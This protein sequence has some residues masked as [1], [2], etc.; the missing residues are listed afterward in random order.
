MSGSDYPQSNLSTSQN[1]IVFQTVYV[2]RFAGRIPV[3]SLI[4]LL[5]LAYEQFCN[6]KVESFWKAFVT[7]LI[8]MFG[9]LNCPL[10]CFGVL[11]IVHCILRLIWEFSWYG[12]LLGESH[13]HTTFTSR[14]SEFHFLF[15]N[16]DMAVA[17][18]GHQVT[19]LLICRLGRKFKSSM[20]LP[21]ITLWN[22][23]RIANT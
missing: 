8:V 2:Y 22:K 16:L 10:I 18:V 21:G 17:V 15:G 6:C 4:L 23:E 3:N 19:S 7:A 9:S 20:R 14:V 5:D 1:K 13:T 11:P 12:Y